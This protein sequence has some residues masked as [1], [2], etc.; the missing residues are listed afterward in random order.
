[1]DDEIALLKQ[2]EDIICLSCFKTENNLDAVLKKFTEEVDTL[3]INV[4]KLHCHVTSSMTN[5]NV[6]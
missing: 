4:N 5:V 6:V 2:K 3:G 1:M